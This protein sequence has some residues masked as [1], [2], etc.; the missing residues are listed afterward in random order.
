[1]INNE[2][3]AEFSVEILEVPKLY[4]P[5]W[6][7][8]LNSSLLYE[9]Q[10]KSGDQNYQYIKGFS[11]WIKIDPTGELCSFELI[12]IYLG[13]KYTGDFIQMN[14][15]SLKISTASNYIN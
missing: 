12:D 10:A 11:G 3:Y 15:D 9:F 2:A 8:S 13:T 4:P 6:I 5:Q 1:M 14:G 7:D